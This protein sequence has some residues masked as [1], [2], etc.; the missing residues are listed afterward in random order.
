MDFKA[1]IHD[2]V[3]KLIALDWPDDMIL[4]FIDGAERT[5]NYFGWH[6]AS[7]LPPVNEIGESETLV[8]YDWDGYAFLAFYTRERGWC[9]EDGRYNLKIKRWCYPPGED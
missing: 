3:N 9:D 7:E 1:F 5:N 4:A 2:K 8:A 6:S